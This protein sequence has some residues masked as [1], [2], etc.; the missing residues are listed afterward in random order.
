M[1]RRVLLYSLTSPKKDLIMEPIVRAYRDQAAAFFGAFLAVVF[2][3]VA[4]R[5]ASR[6]TA[7]VPRGGYGS[8]RP[9]AKQP[10]IRQW[11][12]TAAQ[13]EPVRSRTQRKSVPIPSSY[14]TAPA[15]KWAGDSH[16]RT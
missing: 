2:C 13:Q 6:L 5:S 10:F 4:A 14:S 7:Y 12:A 9:R 8:A 11:A 1:T 15:G 3:R 16:A